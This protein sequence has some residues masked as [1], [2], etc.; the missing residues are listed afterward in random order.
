[1][2]FD[3]RFAALADRVAP[4]PREIERADR[5]FEVAAPANWSDVRVEAWLDWSDRHGLDGAW[6]AL[7]N[8]SLDA[9]AESLGARGVAAG[10]FG[11][12]HAL[13]FSAEVAATLKLGLAAPVDARPSGAAIIDL[14]EPGA[15]GALV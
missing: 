15:N 11:R 12:A 2:R 9:W 10:L 1:M 8:G 13:S 4:A 6:P 7:L 14:N 5:V 3:A